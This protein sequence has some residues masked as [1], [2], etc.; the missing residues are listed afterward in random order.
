MGVDCS[1][2]REKYNIE[3]TLKERKRNKNLLLHYIEQTRE[4][5]DGTNIEKMPTQEYSEIHK[6]D[7]K[8]A[9]KT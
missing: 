2:N 4:T 6:T 9:K 1:C 3:D 7:Q 8:K 5:N